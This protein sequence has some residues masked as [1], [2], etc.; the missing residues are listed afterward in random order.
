MAQKIERRCPICQGEALPFAMIRDRETSICA[1]CRHVSWA[2][3]PSAAEVNAHYT[4]VYSG[5]HGQRDIQE[6]NRAYYR[7]HTEQL[8]SL[9]GG[10]ALSILDFGCSWPISLE[11]ALENDSV[12]SC[13]GVEPDPDA[14]A[15]GSRVG[16]AMYDPDQV[17]DIVDETI[18][19]LRFSHV[20]EHLIDP[21]SLLQTIKPKL[22]PDA[23]LYVTQPAFPVFRSDARPKDLQDAVYPEHLHF[24]S[25]ISLSFLA[26]R[27][28]FEIIEIVAFQE[29]VKRCRE[30]DPF[31]DQ[32]FSE[33]LLLHLRDKSPG[34]FTKLGRYP[35]FH[36]E[37]IHFV[38]RNKVT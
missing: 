5:S 15:Y 23:I 8:V 20:L 27:A 35:T 14:R 30:L 28:D 31:V 25:P 22:K 21:A 19:I 37:N 13:F 18:D 3:F 34:S 11:M 9:H 7:A 4:S 16:L 1:E 24:F 6:A 26:Q 2:K 32:A 36:G 29:E 38:A 17:A 33:K 10:K 12:Q